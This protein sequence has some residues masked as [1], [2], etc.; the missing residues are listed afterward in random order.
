VDHNQA[1]GDK[2]EQQ[3]PDAK[4][5]PEVNEGPDAKEGPE[6]PDV[7][8]LQEGPNDGPNVERSEKGEDKQGEND[9]SKP[10]AP[11]AS[12]HNNRVGSHKP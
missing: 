1:T 3:G 7:K 2:D 11:A 8:D 12:G 9:A 5:G 6:G 10:V 4:E